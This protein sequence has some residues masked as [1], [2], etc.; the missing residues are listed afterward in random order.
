[1]RELIVAALLVMALGLFPGPAMGDCWQEGEMTVCEA[2]EYM[3]APDLDI[4]FGVSVWH[5]QPGK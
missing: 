4:E 5:S 3:P 1:M 2:H